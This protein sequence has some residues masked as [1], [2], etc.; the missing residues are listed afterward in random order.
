MKLPLT[1]R[2]TTF[3]NPLIRWFP[4][5]CLFRPVHGSHPSDTI[6]TLK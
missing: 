6:S 4:I 3:A 5:I 2:A 1:W